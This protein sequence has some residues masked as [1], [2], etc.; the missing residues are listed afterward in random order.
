M[1]VVTVESYK[2]NYALFLTIIGSSKPTVKGLQTIK[3]FIDAAPKWY[4]LG[5]ELLD[6]DQIKQLNNIENDHS[7]STICCRKMLMYWLDSHPYATWYDLV[8]ALKSPSVELK[9]V[10]S[11]VETF[12]GLF[13]EHELC[14]MY[15]TLLHTLTN[16]R[17]FISP[18]SMP[19]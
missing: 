16:F 3:I 1:L 18:Y 6:E 19:V 14:T 10:A 12:I 8:E 4:E 11:T 15:V 17:V 7:E 13:I 9:N 2:S 5:V